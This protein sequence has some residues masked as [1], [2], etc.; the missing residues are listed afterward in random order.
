MRDP[1][2]DPI[3][4][5]VVRS[6]KVTRRVSR[7][8]TDPYAG[9]TFVICGRGT[10]ETHMMP[11]IMWRERTEGATIVKRGDDPRDVTQAKRDALRGAIWAVIRDR[12]KKWADRDRQIHDVLLGMA[13]DVQYAIDEAEN[14]R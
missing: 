12:T 1:R 13:C 5:D 8:W 9:G 6:G 10:G 11:I 7:I 14:A 2:I 3:A 4:G